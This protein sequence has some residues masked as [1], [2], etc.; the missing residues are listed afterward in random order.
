VWVPSAGQIIREA[1]KRAGL[2]Q[3]ELARRV[4]TTQSAIARLENGGTSPSL[5]RVGQ[6]VASAGLELRFSLA[7]PDEDE[8][9]SVAR[10]LGLTHQQRWD[11]TVAAARFVEAGRAAVA[12]RR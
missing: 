7:I 6:L 10:N 3:A 11:K 5:E 12:A 4:G 8:W 9:A 2:T 1:R